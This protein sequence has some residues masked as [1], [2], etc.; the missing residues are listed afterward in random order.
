MKTENEIRDVL[1]W[2]QFGAEDVTDVGANLPD[3][4][5]IRTFI[6]ALSWVLKPIAVL[7]SVMH[8]DGKKQY[9]SSVDTNL[10]NVPTC[11]P[12]HGYLSASDNGC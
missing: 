3:I 8:S 12:K 10:V 11:P 5:N 6:L 7:T 2:L 1:D 4:E 9:P